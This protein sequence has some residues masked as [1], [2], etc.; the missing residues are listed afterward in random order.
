[1]YVFVFASKTADAEA[2]IRPGLSH[3][4]RIRATAATDPR[5]ALSGGIPGS[6]LEP[7]GR[8]WSHFVGIYR[9]KLTRSRKN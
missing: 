6:F 9:H 7:L 2:M 3:V 5:E 4:C 1:M 8:S